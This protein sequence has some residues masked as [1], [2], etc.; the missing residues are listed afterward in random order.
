MH[1]ALPLPRHRPIRPRIRANLRA[2]FKQTYGMVHGG[3]RF[4]GPEEVQSLCLSGVL[5][6]KGDGQLAL[7]AARYGIHELGNSEADVL[8]SHTP[9]QRQRDALSEPV[10]PASASAQIAQSPHRD[11]P[12]GSPVWVR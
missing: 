3:Q 2:R 10:G 7:E 9:G 11:R 1:A 5:G 8:G 6:A 12:Y 4:G